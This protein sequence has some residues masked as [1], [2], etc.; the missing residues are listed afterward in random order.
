M[1]DGD[2][3]LLE[4]SRL[5]RVIQ[6]DAGIE[7]IRE[8]IVQFIDKNH[9]SYVDFENLSILQNLGNSPE[10]VANFYA[11]WGIHVRLTG[12]GM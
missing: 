10:V 9:E 4:D 6:K 12:W 3:L 11:A 8:G 2:V 5:L 1:K 7:H